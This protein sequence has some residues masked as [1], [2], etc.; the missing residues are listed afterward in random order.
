MMYFYFHSLVMSKLIP[1]QKSKCVTFYFYFYFYFYSITCLLCFLFIYFL[2]WF[3]FFVV[4]LCVLFLI[5]LL[6]S[7]RDAAPMCVT[8]NATLCY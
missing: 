2:L 4:F 7:S 5:F 8:L 3:F 6:V 1:S